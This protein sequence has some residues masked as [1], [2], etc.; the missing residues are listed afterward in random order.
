MGKKRR[1]KAGRTK[2]ASKHSTHPRAKFLNAVAANNKTVENNQPVDNTKET[3]SQT[4]A[5]TTPTLVMTAPASVVIDAPAPKSKT[6]T[7]KTATSKKKT[8]TTN[9]T[10]TTK[11]TTRK[12]N[13]RSTKN[14]TQSTTS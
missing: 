3:V 1:L 12:S 14:N 9:N 4:V 2:F 6:T 8:T 13:R 5:E 7:T 10:S 11:K